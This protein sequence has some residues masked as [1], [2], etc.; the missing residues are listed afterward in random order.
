MCTATIGCL[1][2]VGA[3]G[4]LRFFHKQTI[5]MG[6]IPVDYCKA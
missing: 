6:D 2:C 4:L 1:E 3:S 5:D